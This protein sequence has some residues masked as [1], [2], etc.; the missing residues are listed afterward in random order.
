MKHIFFCLVHAAALSLAAPA[1]A[2][3]FYPTEAAVFFSPNGGAED[4]I[5]R[6]IDSAKS[7]IRMQAFL[8]SNK[9]ITGALIRAHQR[10]VKVDVIIDKKM[11]KKK[12]NTTEDLI[13]AGVPTFFDTA[14]RT[15]HDKIIIVDDDIVLTGSFNFVKVAETKNGENLLIFKS[16]PLAEEYVKNWEK[17]FTHSVPAAP[18]E[19][20]RF[21]QTKSS[22]LF[23]YQRVQSFFK[24]L[25][26]VHARACL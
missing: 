15:A 23:D 10:G 5:V 11:P 19:F 4:A 6:S 21:R 9:E 12:P 26:C 20:G 8:F 25:S 2:S 3:P 13:E 17:H 14:H 1:F 18:P 24:L 16:K 7:R 22:Q